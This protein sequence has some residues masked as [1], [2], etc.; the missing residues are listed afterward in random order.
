MYILILVFTAVDCGSLTNPTDGQVDT[1]NGTIFGSTATYTCFRESG[2]RTCR[3]DGM[4]TSVQ[5]NCQGTSMHTISLSCR[6]AK[7]IQFDI[8][9]PNSKTCIK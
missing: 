7:E 1:S 4:W 6:L 9:N 5:P 8:V 3:A 2:S